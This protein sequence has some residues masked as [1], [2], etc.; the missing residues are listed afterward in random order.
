MNINRAH[1]T[2]F[3]HHFSIL[4][5]V[6]FLLNV[7]LDFDEQLQFAPEQPNSVDFARPV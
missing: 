5:I 1:R 3:S 2:I 7:K 6:A 4:E